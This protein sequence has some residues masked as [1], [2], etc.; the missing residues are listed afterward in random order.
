MA[1]SAGEIMKSAN[2]EVVSIGLNATEVI[3][4]GDWV[5]IDANGDCIADTTSLTHATGHYVALETATGSASDGGV[6][7]RI[8]IPNTYVYTK[9]GGNIKA[10]NRVAV[11]SQTT[12]TAQTFPANCAG[13]T[14]T[15]AE[16]DAVINYIKL[17]VGRYVGLE[18]DTDNITDAVNTNVIGVR[19]G[20]D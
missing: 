8:A 18:G 6:K 4:K 1:K 2:I 9:A 10:L 14:P 20:F 12:V 16:L 17:G 5:T 15:T 13:A 3:T 19:L 7:I 11:A